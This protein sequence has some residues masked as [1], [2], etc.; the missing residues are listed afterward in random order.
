MSQIPKPILYLWSPSDNTRTR[1]EDNVLWH[2]EQT[3]PHR[4]RKQICC[5]IPCN[6]ISSFF[7]FNV[8]AFCSTVRPWYREMRRNVMWDKFATLANSRSIIMRRSYLSHRLSKETRAHEISLT[9]SAMHKRKKKTE[10]I[11]IPVV[12]STTSLLLVFLTC[13][14]SWQQKKSQP[15]TQRVLTSLVT[16]R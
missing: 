12:G 5:R 3:Q 8:L 11:Y 7:F 15:R 16:N 13:H 4:C 10:F 1:Y 14:Q 2:P 9:I 6:V